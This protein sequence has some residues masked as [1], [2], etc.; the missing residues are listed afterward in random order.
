MAVSLE[1]LSILSI[2]LVSKV[3]VNESS[4]EI[5]SSLASLST[6][7]L[8]IGEGGASLKLLDG[9]SSVFLSRAGVLENSGGLL[10]L[11]KIS[12]GDLTGVKVEGGTAAIAMVLVVPA[13]KEIWASTAFTTLSKHVYNYSIMRWRFR[14][15]LPLSVM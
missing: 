8:R 5:L 4:E 15:I 12:P 1:M 14:I 3:S 9:S 6:L 7:L 13:A 11:G 10:E 2:K